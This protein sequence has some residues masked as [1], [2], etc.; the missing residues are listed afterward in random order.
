MTHNKLV[1]DR[2]PE[3]I[4]KNGGDPKT[5]VAVS[6]QFGFALQE[7]LRE[8]VEEFCKSEEI[9]EIADILEVLEALMVYHG[10]SRKKVAE[11]K[12]KKARTNGKFRKRIILEEA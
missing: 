4:R 10:F 11:I 9:E 7:K 2:I 5:H 3:I 8:E 6:I 12:K 1:R